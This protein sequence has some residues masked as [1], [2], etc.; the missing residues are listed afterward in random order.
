MGR[1]NQADQL[2]TKSSGTCYAVIL[3]AHNSNTNNLK[4]ILHC[5]LQ[6]SKE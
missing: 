6:E 5:T 3:V 4:F 2:I 1:M